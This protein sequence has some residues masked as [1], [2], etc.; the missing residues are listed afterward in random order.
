MESE[1]FFEG[2]HVACERRMESRLVPGVQVWKDVRVSSAILAFLTLVPH[3]PSRSADLGSLHPF[4][5]VSSG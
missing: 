3:F 1:R 2:L 5:C 4:S